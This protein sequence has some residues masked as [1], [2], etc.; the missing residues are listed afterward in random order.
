MLIIALTKNSRLVLL[1][2]GASVQIPNAMVSIYRN[3]LEALLKNDQQGF[4]AYLNAYH[5]LPKNVPKY[6]QQLINDILSIAFKEFHVSEKFSFAESQIFD[7]VTPENVQELSKLTA[8][9]Y[10]H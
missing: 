6:L 9:S 7:F 5:L 4:L 3:L 8:T 10:S 1:D 2:F